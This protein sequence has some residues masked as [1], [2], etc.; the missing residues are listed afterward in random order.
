[1]RYGDA[2][3]VRSACSHGITC[4]RSIAGGARAILSRFTFKKEPVMS[5]SAAE[6]MRV[7]RHDVGGNGCLFGSRLRAA[8]R[9]AGARLVALLR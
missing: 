2:G 1:M 4:M 3:P 9:S 7:Y 6:R 8:S 5:Q